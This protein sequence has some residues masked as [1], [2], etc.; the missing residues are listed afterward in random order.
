MLTSAAFYVALP[1]LVFES[2]MG[3]ELSDVLGWRLVGTVAGVK[4][5]LAPVVAWAV[6]LALAAS[7]TTLRA[8][9]LM[10]AMPRPSRRTSARANSAVTPT[11]PPRPFS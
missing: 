7:P 1:A 2:T 4:L 3:R 5:L 10:L 9:V 8:V 6:F 11:S